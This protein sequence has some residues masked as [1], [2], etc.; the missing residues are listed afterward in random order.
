MIDTLAAK[1][2]WVARL[3][4]DERRRDGVRLKTTQAAE[5]QAELI[6]T[7]GRR[8]L[9]ELRATV[10]RD[11]EAFRGE[12]PG[13]AARRIL[14]DVDRPESGFAVRKPEPPAGAVTVAPNLTTGAISC[15]YLFT[16]T[17]GMPP[18]RD[19][20]EFVFASTI[21][22][23]LQIKLQG[24]AQLFVDADTLSE[25]LLLPVLTGRPR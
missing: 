3:A 19:H 21:E 17:N 12:F 25:Y 23:S 14:L 7:H 4:D 2:D 5:H 24:T 18:R 1:A 10:A 22:G 9:D 11:I 15:E 6:R 8:I 13:D 16:P 20:L